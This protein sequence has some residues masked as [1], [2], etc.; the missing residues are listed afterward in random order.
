M[1]TSSVFG[2]PYQDV[3]GDLEEN[4]ELLEELSKCNES[5]SDGSNDSCACSVQFIGNQWGFLMHGF[6]YFFMAGT[7]AYLVANIFRAGRDGK[8]YNNPTIVCSMVSILINLTF[9]FYFTWAFLWDK[10]EWIGSAVLLFLAACTSVISLVKFSFNLSTYTEKLHH[11]SAIDL[12][13]YRILVQNTL[14]L[15]TVWTFCLFLMNFAIALVHNGNIYGPSASVGMI[16]VLTFV[17]A[18]WTPLDVMVWDRIFRYMITPFAVLIWVLSSIYDRLKDDECHD[19][20]VRVYTV[21]LLTIVLTIFVGRILLT[22]Y[23]HLW[24]PLAKNQ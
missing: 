6:M 21:V 15:V 1:I 9:I 18:V 19:V 16:I 10:S 8:V 22:V 5:Q 14:A 11:E 12:W 13:I 2:I 24:K 20:T 17:I 3:V 7:I 23:R 4:A